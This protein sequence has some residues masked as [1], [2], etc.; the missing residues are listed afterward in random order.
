MNTEKGQINRRSGF[1]EQKFTNCTLQ[2]SDCRGIMICITLSCAVETSF[3][4]KHDRVKFCFSIALMN[5][6]VS[7]EHVCVQG[8]CGYL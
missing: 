7:L 5:R 8:I 1:V 2:S 3:L 4:E 6:I